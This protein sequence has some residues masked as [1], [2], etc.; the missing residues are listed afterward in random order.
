MTTATA[1]KTTPFTCYQV[2][3]AWYGPGM[4]LSDGQTRIDTE[5]KIIR[6]V[7]VVG[8][9]SVNTA[10]IAGFPDALGE[11]VMDEPYAYAEEALQEALPLYE[12]ARV[13]FD[14]PSSE[15]DEDGR[16]V[17]TSTDRKFRDRLGKLINCV[18]VAGQG[19]FADLQYLASEPLVPKLLE[20]AVD[21]P[22]TIALSHRAYVM[23][24]RIGNRVVVT[25]VSHVTSVDLITENPGTTKNLF[26]SSA[27]MAGEPEK[28]EPPKATEN[29]LP[30]GATPPAR[31]DD[32]P[33]AGGAAA[34]VTTDPK[35]A[36]LN[37]I[38]AACDAIIRG[39]GTAQEKLD[40]MKP[41]LENQDTMNEALGGGAGKAAGDAEE[42][43]A[44]TQL[45][46]RDEAMGV[47]EAAG[48]KVT[49][50]R[51][52]VIAATPKEAHQA[53]LGEYARLD[54]VTLLESTPVPARSGGAGPTPAQ[55][56]G[57]WS[58][59]DMMKRLESGAYKT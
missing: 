14:H 45:R 25:K 27:P 43:A 15:I 2:R 46:L 20:A 47:L 59:D 18:F 39:E 36:I 24:S 56:A 44:R 29:M 11:D 1:S 35:E 33:G 51:I 34:P 17:T 19:I 53:V 4:P 49:K 8:L 50:A 38:C 13:F 28:K 31:E 55:P 3:E 7:K 54:G 26:E 57:E 41:L 6:G 22:E 37:G 9:E 21:M 30:G 16:R 58:A 23:P 32:L 42:S 12:G 52:A 10:R 5:A 48:V 40:K